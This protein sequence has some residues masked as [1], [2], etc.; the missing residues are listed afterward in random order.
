MRFFKAIEIVNKPLILWQL[1]A[2]SIE[3]Y[4]ALG[5]ETDNLVLPEFLVPDFVFGVCPLKVVDN[6][7]VD[8]TIPEMELFEAEYEVKLIIT[9]SQNK[10]TYLKTETFAFDGKN[11]FMDESSRLFYSAIEKL[12]GNQ[13]VL[14][15]DGSIYSLLDSSTNI[16]DFL[17]AYYEKLML[18]TKPNI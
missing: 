10:V 11:F 16:D 17:E 6:D 14:A 9:E 3:D 13:K 5:L 4:F 7:L 18:V 15:T 2:S 12:R 1:V 8:R